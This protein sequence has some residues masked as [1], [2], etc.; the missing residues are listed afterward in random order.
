MEIRETVE[1]TVVAVDVDDEYR[2]E[3]RARRRR[4]ALSPADAVAVAHALLS[5]A[6]RAEELAAADGRATLADL[7]ER[8]VRRRCRA[9]DGSGGWLGGLCVVCAGT[10][11][12]EG[13]VQ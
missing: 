9:C 12:V 7:D 1:R 13:A 3:V 2:V 11:E 4:V 5:S 6:R 10:G 8:I